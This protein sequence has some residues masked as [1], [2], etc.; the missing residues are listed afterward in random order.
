[1]NLI[2]VPILLVSCLW[3]LGACDTNVLALGDWSQPVANYY[4]TAVRGR[5]LLCEYPEHRA[6]TE[7]SDTAVYL[8]L[9]EY[10]DF[11]AG[12]LELYCD[13]VGKTSASPEG[14]DGGL[15]CELRDSSG[16]L[17]PKSGFSFGGGAPTPCWVMLEPYG[18]VQLRA[19]VYGG[20]RLWDGGLGLWFIGAGS[21]V[22]EKAMTQTP[23]FC[24][25]RSAL[26]SDQSCASR[27]PLPLARDVE[28]ACNEGIG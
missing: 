3:C 8:E 14:Y 24:Q 4:G 25:E 12:R 5:L 2:T 6:P 27:F 21:W 20:G 28:V 16:K 7:K 11:V 26:P 9:Q 22:L 17:V 10:S 18:S 13:M 1:M 19:S 15:R 23:I